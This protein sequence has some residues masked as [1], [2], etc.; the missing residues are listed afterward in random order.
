MMKMTVERAYRRAIKTV[1]KWVD[2][3]VNTSN[4]KV[5]FRTFSPVH[6]R[7]A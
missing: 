2:R 4:T 3:E 5:F 1:V 6:F 7:F